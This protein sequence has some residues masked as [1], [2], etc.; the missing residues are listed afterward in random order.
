MASS[1]NELIRIIDNLYTRVFKQGPVLQNTTFKKTINT[2]EAISLTE[3][4]FFL[5]AGAIMPSVYWEPLTLSGAADGD[6][7]DA[8]SY[9]LQSTQRV[10]YL[11]TILKDTIG[12]AG[13]GWIA[14]RMLPNWVSTAVG[15]KTLFQLGT[16]GGFELRVGYQDSTNSWYIKKGSAGQAKVL[17]SSTHLNSD[18]TVIARWNGGTVGITY[19]QGANLQPFVNG[20]GGNVGASAGMFD[21]GSA[22]GGGTEEIQATVRWVVMGTG[23]LSDADAEVIHDIGNTDPTLTTLP[24]AGTIKPVFLWPGVD[25]THEGAKYGEALYV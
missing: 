2:T 19:G 7:S 25:S 1:I 12:N 15:D 11:A 6:P 8:S 16:T 14:V 23:V 20:A 24:N 10:Q 18:M 5:N 4:E 21:I 22:G 17:R 13:V 3:D 9:G